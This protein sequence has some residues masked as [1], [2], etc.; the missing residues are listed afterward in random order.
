MLSIFSDM[1]ERIMEVY[2]DDNTIYGGSFKECLINLETVLHRCIEKYLVLN[3]EKCHFMVSQGK[4]PFYGQSGN[5]TGAY[6]F[7]KRNRS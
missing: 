2:M 1:V 3:W 5:F 4:M 6:Y 7:R